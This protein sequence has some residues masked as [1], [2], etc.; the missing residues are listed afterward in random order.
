MKY[1]NK[2]HQFGLSLFNYQDDVRS[3]KR[4]IYTYTNMTK[5]IV[6]FRNF[7]N[8]PKTETDFNQSSAD[9]AQRSS[10]V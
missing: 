5:L 8:G 6:A 1:K 10:S 3:I 9:Q 4:K 2:W 7:A